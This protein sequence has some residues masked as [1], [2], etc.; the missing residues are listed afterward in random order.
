LVKV[1][2][3]LSIITH[4]ASMIARLQTG[5]KQLDIGNDKLC[6][7]RKRNKITATR[8]QRFAQRRTTGTPPETPHNR[9]ATKNPV[10]L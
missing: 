5:K 6:F 1:Y 10:M 8:V 9:S 7:M 2:A 3:S 4:E